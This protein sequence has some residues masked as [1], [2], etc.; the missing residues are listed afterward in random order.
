MVKLINIDPQHERI[1]F[2][3]YP[4]YTVEIDMTKLSKF[5]LKKD[6]TSQSELMRLKDNYD[7]C[8]V[9]STR[10]YD[11]M[12]DANVLREKALSF[13]RE[14]FKTRKKNLNDIPDEDP[15]FFIDNLISFMFTGTYSFVEDEGI[16]DLFQ[17]YGTTQFEN[18][19]MEKCKQ[20]STPKVVASMFTFISKIK[21]DATTVFYKRKF[22]SLGMKINKNFNNAFTYY[23]M[24]KD[25]TSLGYLYFFQTLVK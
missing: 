4:Q 17:S 16:M 15:Q 3:L 1:L 23:Q 21:E 6:I 13:R 19:F 12:W 10:L 18:L 8:L 11:E 9:I 25:N 7:D 22:Q 24:Y 20:F 14:R 5:I 2:F